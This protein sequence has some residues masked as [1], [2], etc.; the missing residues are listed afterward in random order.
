MDIGWNLETIAAVLILSVI[1]WNL[2]LTVLPLG[3]GAL[4]P[5][6]IRRRRLAAAAL[7]V[8]LGLYGLS[9]AGRVDGPPDR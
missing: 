2:P 8:A 1:G 4:D 6:A 9:Q 7:V 3:P 5:K